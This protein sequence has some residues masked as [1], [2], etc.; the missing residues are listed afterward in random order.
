[1]PGG[2]GNLHPGGAPPSKIGKMLRY[3]FTAEEFH[4]LVELARKVEEAV[5]QA[6]LEAPPPDLG[7]QAGTETFTQEVLRHLK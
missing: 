4:R 3:R 6:L 1:G 5:A 2:D 7:G